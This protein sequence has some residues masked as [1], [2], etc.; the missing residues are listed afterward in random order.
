MTPHIVKTQ[1]CI[2]LYILLNIANIISSSSRLRTLQ[3]TVFLEILTTPNPKVLQIKSKVLLSSRCKVILYVKVK[4]FTD[5]LLIVKEPSP[6]ENP[7]N[8]SIN[9]RDS[10]RG[11]LSKYLISTEVSFSWVTKER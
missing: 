5:G 6:S 3:I 8:H 2:Y 10:I 1:K 4:E 9:Y 7:R 11:L